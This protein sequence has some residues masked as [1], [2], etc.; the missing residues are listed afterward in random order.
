GEQRHLAG[1][2]DGPGHILLLLR[3]VAR[4]APRPDLRSVGHE[5]PQQVHVLPIDVVDVLDAEDAGLLLGPAG[6]VLVL[7]A[8]LCHQN[9]SS[10]G[11]G[12]GTGSFATARE[13]PPPPPPPLHPPPPSRR[14]LRFTSAVAQRRLGPTSS[15]TISTTERRSPS[16]V[17]HERCS[18]RPATTTRAPFSSDS[19]TFCAR[20]RKQVTLKNEVLSSHCWDSRFCHRRFTATPKVVTGA[21]AGVNRSSGS[22]VRLPT[23]VTLDD[24]AV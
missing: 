8:G 12:W 10:S 5:A 22:R 16:A 15:A 20:S 1:V 21:P 24:T 2:L 17:S 4:D 14:S 9:G 6:V 18:R 19:L 13:L 7:R 11:P 3:A 23:I